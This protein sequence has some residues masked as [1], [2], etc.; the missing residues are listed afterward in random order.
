MCSLLKAD[1][2]YGSMKTAKNRCSFI[3][4]DYTLQEKA[5]N[6]DKRILQLNRSIEKYFS[7]RVETIIK[8]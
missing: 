7:E 3:N 8:Q 2:T 6:V 4:D 5:Y 1:I